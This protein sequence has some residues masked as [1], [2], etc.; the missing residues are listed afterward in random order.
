MGTRRNSREA[1]LQFLYQDDFILDADVT[2]DGLVERF[3]QFCNIYQVNKKGRTYAYELIKGVIGSRDE[4]DVIIERAAKNWRMS[5]IS[6]TD[7]NLMRVATYE[8]K[9]RDDVPAQVAINEAVE[10]SKRFCS[11]DSPKFVNGVLD[12]VKTFFEQEGIQE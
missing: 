9:F 7:R 5:R 3:D 11:E 8:M 10:I 6:A 2:P 4:L 12:A 1:A